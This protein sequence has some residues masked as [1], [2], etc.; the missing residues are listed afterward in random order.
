MSR[1]VTDLFTAAVEAALDT[2]GQGEEIRWD[3]QLAP[4]D[5][6]GISIVLVVWL[7]SGTIGE[8]LMGSIAFHNPPP[9]AVGDV[10]ANLRPFLDGLRAERTRALSVAQNGAQGPA[11]G[12]S[13]LILP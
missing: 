7:P 9:V 1:R 12:R 11:T 10:E 6:G 8:Y 13:G 5:Q 3:T 2:H 4:N